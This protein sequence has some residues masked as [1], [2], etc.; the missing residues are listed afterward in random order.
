MDSMDL[1]FS[2]KRQYASGTAILVFSG[3]LDSS[4]HHSMH[5]DRSSHEQEE[6]KWHYAKNEKWKETI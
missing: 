4:I 6:K 5:H 3:F 1:D 2:E